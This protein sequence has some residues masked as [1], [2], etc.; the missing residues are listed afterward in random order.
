VAFVYLIRHPHTQQVRTVPTSQWALSEEGHEQMRRLVAAPFWR[1]V[2]TVYTSRQPK[3]TLVGDAVRAAHGI[4]SV[5][6]DDLGEA[7]REEWVVPDSFQAAQAA[8]FSRVHTAPLPG[9]EPA[10]HAQRRFTAAIEQVLARHHPSESVAIVSHASV[11]TLYV[12][13]ALHE[14]PSY[15]AWRTLGFAAVMALDR[16][17][18]HPI[19]DFIDPPYAGLPYHEGRRTG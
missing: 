1:C 2:S 12:A 4:P 7:R 5:A 8:F 3:T 18:L 9:W 6:V 13:H 15:D 16:K 11:L 14:A 17:S 19:T 10:L